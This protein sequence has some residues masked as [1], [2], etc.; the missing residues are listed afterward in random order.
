MLLFP[1]HYNLAN[2]DNKLKDLVPEFSHWTIA[3]TDITEYNN[4]KKYV[5]I[6]DKTRNISI[7]DYLPEVAE[8]YGI[9]KTE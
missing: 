3:E 8:I 7:V 4:F 9:S 2:A 6:L 1:K 5:N